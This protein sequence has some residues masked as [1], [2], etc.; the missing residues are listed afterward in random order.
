MGKSANT[1]NRAV[2]FSTVSKRRSILDVL[3]TETYSKAELVE[4]LSVS[5]STIDRGIEEL[6]DL[7]LVEHV[8]GEFVATNTG[9]VALQTHDEALDTFSNVLAADA[10]LARLPNGF[11]VPT[12]LFRDAIVCDRDPAA[13]EN[14]VEAVLDDVTA[15][16]GF[17]GPFRYSLDPDTRETLVSL[18][19]HARFVVSEESLSWLSSQYGTALD[20]VNDAGVRIFSV[21]DAPPYGVFVAERTDN[22]SVTLVVYNHTGGVEAVLVSYDAQAVEWACGLVSEHAETG[23]PYRGPDGDDY[24]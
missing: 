20:A 11:D 6:T 7:G 9:V 8:S 21:A 5:R 22:A 1:D 10:V 17:N 19:E 16:D 3:T 15:I 13:L 18:G 24:L 2:D 4:L 14:Q 23:T 12:S